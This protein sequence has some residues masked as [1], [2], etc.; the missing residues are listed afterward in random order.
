IT[1]EVGRQ[2]WIVYEVMRVDAAVT[3]AHVIPFG[4]GALWV[5]YL[6]LGGAVW[7]LLR[8]F[9]RVPLDGSESLPKGLSEGRE[10]DDHAG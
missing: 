1:T 8:R 2:P 4:Y 10:V 6:G 9:S 5:V 3:G 7:W